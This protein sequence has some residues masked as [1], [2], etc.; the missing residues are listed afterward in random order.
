M[1]LVVGVDERIPIC[2]KGRVVG[3][4]TDGI[5]LAANP[6]QWEDAQ[7]EGDAGSGFHLTKNLRVR[8]AEWCA[9]VF[10]GRKIATYNPDGQKR[11]STV[12][13]C[14]AIAFHCMRPVASK[15]SMWVG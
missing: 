4:R 9:A 14:V 2:I 6:R 1:G 15:I 5:G 11:M 7:E 13:S 3:N 8:R 10:H 12:I